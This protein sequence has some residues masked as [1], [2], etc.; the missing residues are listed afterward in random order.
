VGTTD[1]TF[2]QFSG[3]GQ[4]TANTA[5]GLSLNGTVFS[6]KVDEN[7]TA[8]DGSGNIIVKAGANLTTPN[9]GAATGTSLSTAGNITGNVLIG[10]TIS[11]TGNVIAGNLNAAGLSLSSNV[12]SNLNVTGAIAGANCNNTWLDISHRQHHWW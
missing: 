8:F 9:I 5:A 6:A 7:T 11:T 2:A 12:V 1:I 10:S 4:Y 3:A